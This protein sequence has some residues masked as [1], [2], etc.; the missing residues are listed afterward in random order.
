MPLLLN[1]WGKATS[2]MQRRK[3]GAPPSGLR[4]PLSWPGPDRRPQKSPD[5][6]KKLDSLAE[7]DQRVRTLVGRYYT[8]QS[9]L[10][11]DCFY[12]GLCDPDKDNGAAHTGDGPIHS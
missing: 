4:T 2:G 8:R 12:L 3:P 6:S 1:S 9:S 10:H 5:T 7:S 11:G